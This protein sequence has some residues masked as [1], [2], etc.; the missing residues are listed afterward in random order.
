MDIYT[1]VLLTAIICIGFT[2]VGYCLLINSTEDDETPASEWE[3]GKPVH[4][5]NKK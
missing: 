5:R 1:A 2:I 3:T 4:K